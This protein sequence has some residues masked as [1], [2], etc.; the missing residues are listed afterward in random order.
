MRMT[1]LIARKKKG[2]RLTS[3]E[4]G[5]WVDGIV[6]ESIPRYQSA[7]LLM[8]IYFR[9]LAE[10]ETVALTE[11]MRDSGETL[12]LT[13]IE[14][15]TS[16]KHST[17]GVGDKL[18]F[19]IGPLAAACGVP[20]PML[21]GRALGHTGGTLDKLEAIPGYQTRLS[22]ERFIEI[23][24]DV[25]ISIIGQ[26]ASLAPADKTLYSLRDVTGTVESIPL[27]VS[28]ILS[29]KLAA[30]PETL[31]FDVKSGDGAFLQDL[32]SCRKLAET[33]V[34]VSGRMGRPATAFITNMNTPIGRM[35]G[36]G[37]EIAES[38]EVLRGGDGGD[39]MEISVALASE[40][41]LLSGLAGSEVEARAKVL[42]ALT[43]GKGAETFQKMIV[44]HGGDGR[45]VDDPTSIL[46]AAR[47][48]RELTSPRS[49]WIDSIGA[50][51]IGLA[52]TRLGA[53]RETAEDV[54]SPG[55]GIE[56]L[57]KPGDEVRAGEPVA[58]LLADQEDRFD[59]VSDDVLAAYQV[60]DK[61]GS[62][63]IMIIET[64]RS[65]ANGGEKD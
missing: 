42:D 43:S 39:M 2:G 40:M 35:V 54:V 59:R 50:R 53:G 4:I 32:D 33:L 21:S 16:D 17:G 30:G 10:E 58:I 23:V 63:D 34:R 44:A 9:D 57:K 26:T 1:D 19:L 29:K 25:G 31:V 51:A 62:P 41:V 46:P 7:A 12:D 27:I 8:A 56:L 3:E 64:I 49:G 48:K 65:H 14:G 47:Y 20:V 5:F 24:R 55:A 28:S 37:I 52:A 45:V 6:S 11:I 60:T 36:N 15:R 22:R 38:I 18:S 13:S 61:K